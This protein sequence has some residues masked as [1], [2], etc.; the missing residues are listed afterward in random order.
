MT[1]AIRLRG[2]TWNHSRGFLP[3]V[4]TAQR[5]GETH[6][7]VEIVWEKRSLQEFA[8]YPVER[9][10]ET[11]DLLVVDHPFVGYAARHRVFIPLDE[12]PDKVLIDGFL[13][14]Q[15]R[16]SAGASHAS[17]FYDGRQWAL[18]IDAATPV[19][20]WRPDLLERAQTSP[21]ENWEDLLVLAKRG[22][23]AFPAIPIDSLMNFYM[24]CC[25]LGS[26]PFPAGNTFVDS[27]T[28]AEALALLREL[29][30][31]CP[32]E[33]LNWNPIAVYEAM[34]SRSD[35]AYCPFAYGYSNYARAGY[36]ANALRFGDLG[37]IRGGARARST[38]GGTGL[39]IS[40]GCRNP[41]V[42]FQYARYV[43]SSDCQGGLYLQS[44]GQ[45]GRLSAWTSVEAN[46]LTNDFFKETLPSIERA[47]L[48]PRY[49]GYIK[50][51]D[52]AAAVVH[53]FLREGGDARPAVSEMRRLFE[54]SQAS[55][56]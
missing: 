29:V 26:E 14:E 23:V 6:P 20:S 35:I 54:L 32:A 36:A 31:L 53:K 56:R 49:C 50:F 38:L 34:A 9:L 47:Y 17:Y 41:D 24:L 12:T 5:F 27:D 25:A 42:A 55:Q 22:W 48:R 13:S 52:Q 10:A 4:A 11:F 28:G 44:G 46:R 2:I 33:I 19:S 21:P 3:M 7:G 16:D 1:S 45:P 51:Q 18:S 15:A 30:A 40:A 39:A 37:R 43:A 8:D